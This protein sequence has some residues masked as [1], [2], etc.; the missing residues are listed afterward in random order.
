MRIKTYILGLL[1]VVGAIPA[2]A[3]QLEQFTQFRFAPLA[4]NPAFTGNDK[5]FNA[6]ALHRTQW[7]GIKDSPRTYFMSLDAPSKSGKMGF[8][9]VIYTDV[10]GP[11]RRFGAQGTY[12]YKVQITDETKLSF[13]LS[14][15]L[16]QFSIDGSQIDLRESGDPSM[17][18]QLE[19]ELKPDASFGLV[20]YSDNYYVGL[21][22][23]Q[24]FNNQLE[25]FPGDGDSKMAVHYYL[26]GAYKFKVSENF[27]IEPAILI[28]YVQPVPVQFDLTARVIYNSNLWLGGSYRTNDAAAVYA[29][30]DI[31]DY[32]T[33]GYSY[34]ITT[35][36]LKQYSDGTH[37]IF[38]QFRFGKPQ[39]VENN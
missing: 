1:C 21:S 36:E 25:L 35:S 14:F 23:D 28:K 32:L 18:G 27:D 16:T 37:E 9:G 38:L 3:Q 33:I 22:A 26:T 4:Y 20:Y 8:G 7:T 13:G 6:L 15:G 29:G 5:Y 10:A 2:I 24:I 11:T 39:M 30:Y 31:M 17:T 12:A 34:D 19:S